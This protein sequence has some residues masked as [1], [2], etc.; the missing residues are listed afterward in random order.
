MVEVVLVI[1]VLVVEETVELVVEA[2]MVEMVELE[3]GAEMV[4]RLVLVV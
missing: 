3:Q 1:Q 4:R 2:G